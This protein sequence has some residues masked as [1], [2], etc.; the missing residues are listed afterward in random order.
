MDR[1]WIEQPHMTSIEVQS[2]KRSIME[3]IN[4]FI[5]KIEKC[6]EDLAILEQKIKIS[7][8]E[9]HKMKEKSESSATIP[10]KLLSLDSK[11]NVSSEC[12]SNDSY[13]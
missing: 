2:A 10:D 7:F 11:V 3:S 4:Q 6:L 1:E 8:D 5:T 12:S 13:C 9:L